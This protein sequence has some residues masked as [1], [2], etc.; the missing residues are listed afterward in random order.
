MNGRL[1]VLLG[2]LL[3]GCAGQDWSRNVYEGLRQRPDT[4]SDPR[5]Q[6][7]PT[8]PDYETY[9]RERQSL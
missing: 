2:L 1:V 6:P 4:G 3:S 5:V 9:R 8:M 7:A